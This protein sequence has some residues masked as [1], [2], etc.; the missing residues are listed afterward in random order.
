MPKH[1]VYVSELGTAVSTPVAVET[2]I[3]FV[4]GLSP[5]H[6]ADNPAAAGE[7]V[8]CYTFNEF[9][10]KFGYSD[11]WETYN[12]CEFAYSQFKLYGMA[13]VIFCNLLAPATMQSAVAAADKD[14]SGHKVVLTVKGIDDAGLVVKDKAE[15]PNTLVKDTDYSVYYNEDGKLTVELLS[16]STHYADTQL[17]ITFNE[18]T[19]ASVN[20]TAIANGL[21]KIELCM[22][23]FGL[24]PD[25]ICAPGFSQNSAVAAVMTA[26]AAGI[27]GMFPAVAIVDIDTAASGG[28]D[29]YDEV[30]ALKNSNNMTGA[31]EIVCWPLAK[32]GDKI[33]HMSTVVAGRIAQT[34][35]EFGAPYASPSNQSIKIDSLV[36][37]AG[38]AVNLT[39]AQANL[40][41]NGGIVTALNFMGGFRLWGNYTGCYPVSTDVKDYFIPIRRMFNWVTCTII[42]TFWD[43]V[44]MPI[45]RRLIDSIIDT[46][47]IWM[48]GLTGSGY[49]F[50]GRIE[51]LEEENPD[52]NIM[53]GM[54]KLHVYITPPSPMQELDFVLEYDASYVEA[55]LGS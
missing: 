12:L 21:E 8:I 4:I 22:S 28:A 19:P 42:R 47:N 50:G 29:S 53:A 13:P 2:G 5:V 31:L 20:A 33:F 23:K 3:P 45:S 43:R 37:A 25:L 27:N 55:A 10:E 49:I 24:V 34:D 44:D 7:P 11:D 48:N 14:V 18:V 1:G 6:T 41:N 51:Y 38:T 26:K 17:N 39:L 52:Q 30:I 35:S 15:T 32:L 40:L 16:T 9:V 54:I 46:A 36:V